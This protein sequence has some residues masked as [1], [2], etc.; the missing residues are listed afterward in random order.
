MAE[1]TVPKHE[2]RTRNSPEQNRAVLRER[3]WGSEEIRGFREAIKR[4]FGFDFKTDV[5]KFPVCES[6]FSWKKLRQKL[7]LR[8]AD[9]SS[10]FPQ[11][12]R[13]GVQTIVNAMYETVPTSFE[14]WVHV[15]PS[16]L[17]TELYAPLHGIGFM[18]EVG[19]QEPYPETGA[20]GLDLKLIN[21]KYGTMWP[22]ERELLEDDQTGQFQK[23]AGLLGEYA[24]LAL[25]VLVMSKLS[26]AAGVY[27]NM[28]VPASETKPST[29]AT[30]PYVPSSAPFVGGGFNR[31]TAYGALT[32][33]NIITGM[34][35]TTQQKNLLGL[36]MGVK[37]DK[38][39]LSPKYEY[40]IGI[41]LNS[42]WY[43]VGAQ[44]AGVTGGAFAVNPLTTGQI[45]ATLTPVISRY[46]FD[47]TGIIP[48]LSSAWYL[49]D[50]SKPAF[51]LQL[52]ETASVEQ[53]A[54][55]AGQSFEREI[56][57]WKVRVRANADYIDPRFFWR[58]SDGSA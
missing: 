39:I 52:R 7:N 38:I 21:R 18:R 29:E 55:N 22:C 23:Q 48:F 9:S 20:A 1:E 15:V 56:Y 13:A 44:A 24:K 47:H 50:S 10:I 37:P 11:V 12:L 54:P 31:P 28:R 26:G 35:T 40:D 14:E 17:N 2:L 32:Q 25:E 45:R 5:K 49:V 4:R 41:L 46:M 19:G 16:K 27:Q 30:Y 43:P 51:V 57:R 8:E 34:Q 53:E 36:F 42:S 33:A 58:G 3:L 6:N